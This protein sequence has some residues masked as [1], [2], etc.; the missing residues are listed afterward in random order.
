MVPGKFGTGSSES[1]LLNRFQHNCGPGSPPRGRKA[2]LGLKL[3]GLCGVE[4]DT[5]N[6]CLGVRGEAVLHDFQ[7][8]QNIAKAGGRGSATSHLVNR[9]AK[10]SELMP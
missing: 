10:L 3:R 4:R 2:L 7:R 5:G 8:S 1:T 9:A 6:L